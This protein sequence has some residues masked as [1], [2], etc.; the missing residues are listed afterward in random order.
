MIK[1]AD[2]EGNVIFWND[3]FENFKQLSLFK[4]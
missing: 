3:K 4:S 1:S 2:V